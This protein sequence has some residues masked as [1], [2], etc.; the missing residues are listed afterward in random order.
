MSKRVHKHI[1]TTGEVRSSRF[2]FSSLTPAS[3]CFS[4]FLLSLYSGFLSQPL[5]QNFF[6]E[7][8][9]NT[10][11]TDFRSWNPIRGPA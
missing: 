7:L 3:M 10:L 2:D 11:S 6:V 8:Q 5:T 9:K 1:S 4:E